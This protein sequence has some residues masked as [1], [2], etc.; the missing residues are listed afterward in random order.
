V[1]AD[2][3]YGES[4]SNFIS[5]ILGLGRE[6]A[7]AIRSNHGVW[8]PSSA[9][10][11]ANKWRAFK[12]KRWD[13]IEENRYIREIIYGRRREIR[14]WDITTDKENPILLIVFSHELHG[15]SLSSAHP[16]GF[17]DFL[18]RAFPID[19]PLLVRR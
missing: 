15:I 7:V 11:R 17:P 18:A 8:L 16:R 12:H 14:Y 3:F 5:I 2:S 9:K 4:H 19:I 6:Y 13:G 1:L 10:V